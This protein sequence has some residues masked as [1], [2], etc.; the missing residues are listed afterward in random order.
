MNPGDD[1]PRRLEGTVLTGQG[2]GDAK[3]G[4]A[5]VCQQVRVRLRCLGQVREEQG[6]GR[7]L[8]VSERPQR[9]RHR[10]EV[11]Q[12]V[13]GSDRS[14]E[15]LGQVACDLLDDETDE[16][17]STPNSL[18]ERRGSHADRT[19]DALHG[20]AVHSVALDD[21]AAGC[22]DLVERGARGCGYRDLL[23]QGS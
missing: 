4:S 13:A 11:T 14:V 15:R 1:R 22:D 18:V 10:A 17:V 20:E 19:G 2:G 21:A 12:R 6:V 8:R 3:D 7:R 9:V 5:H 16:F 23:R